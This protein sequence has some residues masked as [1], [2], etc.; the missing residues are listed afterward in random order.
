MSIDK[1]FED[2]YRGS[3][4]SR[5]AQEIAGR[6][7]GLNWAIVTKSDELGRVKVARGSQGGNSETGWLIRIMPWKFLSVPVPQPGDVVLVG[8]EEGNP[9]GSGFYLGF[10]QNLLNPAEQTGTS[11]TYLWQD[12]KIVLNLQ[13]VL[14]Q[15]GDISLQMVLDEFLSLGWRSE[16]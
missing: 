4:G 10:A 1:L 2:I 16:E 6:M 8:F 9:N 12:L 7:L 3:I 5:A 13:G 14:I 11:W 15:L